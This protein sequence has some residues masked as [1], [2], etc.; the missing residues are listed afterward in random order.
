VLASQSALLQRVLE[1][2]ARSREEMRELRDE[3]LLPERI[4][5]R[6]ERAKDKRRH[7]FISALIHAAQNG[8][9]R[10][11]APFLALNREMWDE[12]V[13]WDAV[14]DIPSPEGGR[15]RLMYAA[16]T[17]DIG[18]LRWLLARGARRS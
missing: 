18:R 11:V 8:F 12:E 1:E 9:G 5:A 4:A 3:L 13:L 17:G 16:K 14:K 6:G 7:N 10:D 15:T 2:L